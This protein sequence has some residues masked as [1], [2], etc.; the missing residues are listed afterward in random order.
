MTTHKTSGRIAIAHPT[1]NTFSRAAAEAFQRNDL[2]DTFHTCIAIGN[3]SGN[4]LSKRLYA[5][6]RCEI[7]QAYLKT[8]PARELTRLILQKKDWL[9]NLRK[10]ETGAFCVD[11]IYHDLDQ[12]VAK[13]LEQQAKKPAAIYAYEDGALA[14]FIAARNCGIPRIYD[15]PIGYWRAARRIQ[16]EEALRLPDWASTMPALIDSESKLERKDEELKLCE[17][18]IVASRFTAETLKEAPF[19]LPTPY[20]IPYGCPPPRKDVSPKSDASKPLRVLYVG[21]L[22]QR[23]GVAYLLDAVE[24]LGSAVELTLIGKR[25]SEC[26]PLDAAL[27]KFHW[28]D[29]LPHSEILNTMREHDVLVFPS[30]FEGFGLVITEALSQGI[31][32]I[33]TSHTCAPDIIEDGREGYIV[34]IR[35]AAAI[36]EKLTRLHEDRDHLQQMK[37][38]ALQRAATM[39]WELYKDGLVHAAKHILKL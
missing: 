21:G 22:S 28:I 34:P 20:I 9:P 18:I 19:D 23:K 1:G 37:E 4:P 2:L 12:H 24:A 29:S 39:S 36:S 38:A 13:S 31:P 35:D 3:D 7:P 8:R 15:L 33:S 14:S 26:A 17:Q 27:K 5:Q 25:V 16:S 30:L 11:S 32:I 10:H 6:R